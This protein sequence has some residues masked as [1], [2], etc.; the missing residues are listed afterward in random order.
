MVTA[1]QDPR[2]YVM[3][4]A[5]VSRVTRQ[6]ATPTTT[7]FFSAIIE[8]LPRFPVKCRL[9]VLQTVLHRRKTLG[10]AYEKVS[11]RFQRAGELL[12]HRRLR[13]LVEVNRHIP[14]EY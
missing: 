5:P 3:M 11:A 6:S 8:S 14:A 12:G 4:D 1:M 7:C 9:N 10:M 2:A 13:R